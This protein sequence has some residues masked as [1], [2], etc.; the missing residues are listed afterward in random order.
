MEAV[1][2]GEVYEKEP[3]KRRRTKSHTKAIICFPLFVRLLPG[4]YNVCLG[5][6]LLTQHSDREVNKR[7]LKDKE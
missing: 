7:P 3:G 1:V 2:E 4:K 6:P 5:G